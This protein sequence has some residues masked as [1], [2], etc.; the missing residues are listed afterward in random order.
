MP[1]KWSLL[2]S[3]QFLLNSTPYAPSFLEASLP[4]GLL[5]ATKQ[6]QLLG[7]NFPLNTAKAI[8]AQCATGLLWL[9]PLF[10]LQR[11]VPYAM[12]HYPVFSN[13]RLLQPCQ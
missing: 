13:C 12:L 8:A 1:L 7:R 2:P 5:Q 3:T 9:Y 6:N 11:M 10:H 4:K